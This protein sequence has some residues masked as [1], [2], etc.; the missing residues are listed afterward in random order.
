[1]LHTLLEVGCYWPV[2]HTSTFLATWKAY[3]HFLTEIVTK[4]YEIHNS[5]SANNILTVSIPALVFWTSSPA[6]SCYL[7][8]KHKLGTMQFSM[9]IS[10]AN[11]GFYYLLLAGQQ[12]HNANSFCD[13]A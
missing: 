12:H 7:A 8:H 2:L 11:D 5:R 4:K 1:M 9:E 3:H 6:C 10:T 13:E